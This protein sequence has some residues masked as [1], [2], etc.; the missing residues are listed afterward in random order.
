MFNPF[1]ILLAI[2]RATAN[3]LALLISR[4]QK[5]ADQVEK[6]ILETHQKLKQVRIW[7]LYSPFTIM[8]KFVT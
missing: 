6:N 1:C 4:M 3:E 7:T 8:V 2:S 5:N